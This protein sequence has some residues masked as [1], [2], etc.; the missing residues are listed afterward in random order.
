M[1]VL[2]KLTGAMAD[3]Q[4]VYLSIPSG[5]SLENGDGR[6]DNSMAISQDGRYVVMILSPVL[7]SGFVT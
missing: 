4:A 5:Y 2:H 1:V 6:F 3:P 7:Q